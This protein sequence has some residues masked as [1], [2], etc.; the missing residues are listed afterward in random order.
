MCHNNATAVKKVASF[1]N[2]KVITYVHKSE[3]TD[4]EFI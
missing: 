4:L 1:S 2:Y 3:E